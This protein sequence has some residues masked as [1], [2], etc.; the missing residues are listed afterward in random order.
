MFAVACFM[1]PDRD[2]ALFAQRPIILCA[3]TDAVS[4]CR[5][6]STSAA[7]ICFNQVYLSNPWEDICGGS[8]SILDFGERSV[9]KVFHFLERAAVCTL[10]LRR[11]NKSSRHL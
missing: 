2:L 6:R 7:G 10:R 8:N 4:V 5:A 1:L 9:A 3:L 11:P